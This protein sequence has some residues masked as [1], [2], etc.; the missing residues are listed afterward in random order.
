M[1]TCMPFCWMVHVY[2]PQSV[3]IYNIVK[4]CIIIVTI[5]YPGKLC[6]PFRV[7]HIVRYCHAITSFIHSDFLCMC[8]NCMQAQ[9]QHAHNSSITVCC[10][11]SNPHSLTHTLIVRIDLATTPHLT[12]TSQF[13]TLAVVHTWYA[14]ALLLTMVSMATW[15]TL[16]GYTIL[17]TICWGCMNFILLQLE[18]SKC[19]SSAEVI[20]ACRWQSSRT[21][22]LGSPHLPQW[23]P[24]VSILEHDRILVNNVGTVCLT[25]SIDCEHF[26]PALCPFHSICKPV[27]P[28][29]CPRTRIL[30]STVVM[31]TSKPPTTLPCGGIRLWKQV[32]LH[33]H[34]GRT[35]LSTSKRSIE[36]W[37]PL[38]VYTVRSLYSTVWTTVN[39]SY[40]NSAYIQMQAGF[41]H[42]SR[43]ILTCMHCSKDKMSIYVCVHITHMC[44]SYTI[45]VH[46]E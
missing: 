38:C 28:R 2:I 29:G 1:C 45:Y 25:I 8:C 16:H 15:I 12:T 30:A 6:A 32:H 33:T 5:T 42:Q 26:A 46:V 22:W 20:L 11:K 23:H 27:G 9:T 36:Q 10:S 17:S 19:L 31:H 43:S 40:A 39:Q 3:R 13:Y 44:T 24:P 41:L 21:I 7:V 4:L 18:Y 34:K 35:A 14:M 37:T